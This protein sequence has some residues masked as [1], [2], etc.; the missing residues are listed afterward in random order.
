MLNNLL[1]IGQSALSNFQVALNVHG[2]NIANA[3]TPGY[4]RR[5]VDFATDGTTTGKI[6]VGANIQGIVRELDAFLERRYLTQSSTTSYYN[7]IAS[8]L[9]QVESLFNSSSDSGI[10]AALDDFMTSLE[11]LSATASNAA[12]RTEAIETA[13]SLTEMLASLDDSLD[14][15]TKS[16]DASIDSQVRSVNSLTKQI[17]A[18]NKSIAGSSESS[19]L[20]DQRDQLLRDLAG[21]VDINVITQ[22]DGQ[23]RVMT[24]EGQSLVDGASS[25]TLRMEGPKAVASL[26]ADSGFDGKL[27][28]EG[29]SSNELTVR[30]VSGGDTSGGAGAATYQVSLDGG[31]TWVQNEDGST[32]VF[33]A[34]DADHKQTVDGV[35]IWFG[36][37]TDPETAP[38]TSI[39]SGDTFTVM[40]KSGVYWVT[41]AGGDVN[42]TPLSGSDSAGRLSGG[43]LAGLLTLRDQYVGEYQD[44]LDAFA[45]SFIWNMNRVHSQG[46]GLTNMSQA[47]GEYAVDN[48]SL[49]LR[50]SGLAW[51]DRLESGNISIALYDKATGKNLSVTALDFGSVPPGTSGF[52][53]SVHSLEDVRDA[54]NASYPGQITASIQNG[55]LSL[56]AASG[57][58]FQFAEDTSGLL[59]GLGINTLFKGTDASSV[60]L[61]DAVANDPSRLCAGHVN[62]AGEVNTGDNTTALA[63]SALAG[64]S[65]SFREAGG[66]TSATLQDY[67][68]SLSAKVGSDSASAKTQQTYA[69][70][71]SDD[72]NMQRESV[73]GVSLDEE[74]TRVMQYQQ[75][76]Q[77]AAKLIQTAGEMFDVVMSLK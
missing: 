44:K 65:V 54:I 26:G 40:P 72:L 35:A 75:Y 13:R 5:T 51:A 22:E 31:K 70:T 34:G 60:A 68:N 4:V 11:N 55:Q 39:S 8:N 56:Q 20:L 17:A 21:Y 42:V 61:S 59:A 23:V 30:F 58:E 41:S 24:G 3:S 33:T 28:F 53:P 48:Q 15:I 76:Y 57:M 37:A 7:T 71:L 46:A 74:L 43:S 50:Q 38:T 10:S 29:A 14:S 16:L 52:D 12:V 6:G 64:T 32:R 45:E 49:P 2:G 19:G 25:Y 69:T 62:G 66:S 47:L 63:L 67:M 73:S 27:Y 36:T 18:L 77:A 1:T 9:S